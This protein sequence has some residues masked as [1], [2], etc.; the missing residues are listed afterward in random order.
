MIKEVKMDQYLKSL[1]VSN[2]VIEFKK[3][4]FEDGYA[5]P[6]MLAR[7]VKV[8]ND[9]D[10]LYRIYVNYSEFE[11]HNK[12][13]EEANYYDDKMNPCLT[14][15]GAG[16]YNIEEFYYLDKEGMNYRD[17]FIPVDSDSLIFKF[18]QRE[19]KDQSYIEWLEERA[20]W[21]YKLNESSGLPT[22][23]F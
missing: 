6:G 22:E 18:E 15:R 13:Y 5:M 9:D 1:H 21:W 7:V 23:K 11:E 14:A 10:N 4:I 3:Q 19:N 20:K 16:W 12:A 2:C 8:T 17:Y